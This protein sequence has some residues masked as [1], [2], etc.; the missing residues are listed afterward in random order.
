MR[1]KVYLPMIV[2]HSIIG[3]LI[4]ACNMEMTHLEASLALEDTTSVVR[5]SIP[6]D[7]EDPIPPDNED[8]NP[9]EDPKPAPMVCADLRMKAV[10]DVPVGVS[11]GNRQNKDATRH[12][13][14]EASQITTT[15]VFPSLVWRGENNFD[16]TNADRA[17]NF[18]AG[19]GQGIHGHCLIYAHESVNP[20]F[21]KNFRGN[22]QEFEALIKRYIQT[23]VGRYK[24]KIKAWDLANELFHYNSSRVDDT[25]MRKRFSSDNDYFDF[26]GRCFRYAHEADPKALLFYNDYGQEFSNG[27]YEKGHAIVKLIQRWKSQGVPIHGYGLQMHTNIYRP[28][29]T[30]E[31]ALRLAASTGLLVH[32]SELDIAINHADWDIS[33]IRGGVQ[34]LTSV[35]D[36]LLSRQ[37]EMYKKVANAY[38][39]S[40]PKNQQYAIT[41]WD[42]CD[43]Y[44]WLNWNRFEAGTL[45]DLNYQR[46]PAFYGF[47]EGLSGKSY[48][49]K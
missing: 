45:F 23:T 41:L 1:K 46:K 25:W 15:E 28:I 13:I 33:G 4:G 6:P 39:R 49:C 11:F 27:N 19:N 17:V 44:S 24:G 30:I 9:P 2:V 12:I 5:D 8:P 10:S 18:A 20:D 43:K 48:D 26:V 42:L 36:D 29:E 35:N 47:L 14:D 7:D 3:L 21:L 31:S 37:R 22:N 16:F 32:I 34:G 38:K 40:V